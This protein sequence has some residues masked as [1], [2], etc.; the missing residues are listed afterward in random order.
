MA[1]YAGPGCFLDLDS[2]EVGVDHGCPNESTGPSG[3]GSNELGPPQWKA[4]LSLWAVISAQLV[5]GN[6]LPAMTDD[7]RELLLSPGYIAVNQ[8]S[9]GPHAP[10][11]PQPLCASTPGCINPRALGSCWG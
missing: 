7:I 9:L 3:G 11:W 6:D 5:L 10:H 1:R 8:D 4:Q 2:L